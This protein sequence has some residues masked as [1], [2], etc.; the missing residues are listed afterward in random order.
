MCCEVCCDFFAAAECRVAPVARRARQTIR[1]KRLSP[2]T[3][4]R[5]QRAMRRRASSLEA[6]QKPDRLD[7]STCYCGTAVV[8]VVDGAV[9]FSFGCRSLA[10]RTAE[11]ASCMPA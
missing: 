5:V 3:T 10:M 2:W 1:R 11:P 6:I 9:G 7:D 4:R 8:V